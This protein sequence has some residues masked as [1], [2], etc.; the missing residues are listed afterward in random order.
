MLRPFRVLSLA[1]LQRCLTLHT[2]HSQWILAIHGYC[3]AC[4]AP[5]QVLEDYVVLQQMDLHDGGTPLMVA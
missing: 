2:S 3:L 4:S 5:F 1:A